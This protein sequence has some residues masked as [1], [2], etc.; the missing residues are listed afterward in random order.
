MSGIGSTI[1]S[2]M[3]FGTGSAIAH[4]YVSSVHVLHVFRLVVSTLL[5]QRTCS[6][7]MHVCCVLCQRCGCHHGR[8]IVTLW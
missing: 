8:W 3:A 4:Q 2:G 6:F 7:E 5:S 1:V